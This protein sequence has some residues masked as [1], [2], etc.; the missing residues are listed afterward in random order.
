MGGNSN[1]HYPGHVKGSALFISL[2]MLETVTMNKNVIRVAVLEM[3][4]LKTSD[5]KYL[6][7]QC[8]DSVY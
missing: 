1:T 6:E 8:I 4:V 5:D 2:T 7:H 3:L